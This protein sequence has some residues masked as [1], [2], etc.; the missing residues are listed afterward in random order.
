[1]KFYYVRLILTN[2]LSLFSNKIIL[3][4]TKI[5]K[6]RTISKLLS[7]R[8][9]LFVKEV[10]KHGTIL[11]YNFIN[12]INIIELNYTQN[13]NINFCRIKNFA[14]LNVVLLA[15]WDPQGIVDSYVLYYAK[16]LKEIGYSIIL[17]SAN[18]VF[19]DDRITDIFDAVIYRKTPGYDFSSW[20]AAFDSLPTLFDVKQLILTNDSV[21]GPIGSLD[22]IFN[23]MKPIIC[24]FWGIIESLT[25][26]PY[27]QSYFI[28]L[29][30]NVIKSKAFRM[31][32]NSIGSSGDR[33]VAVSYEEI[34]SQWL[35]CNNLIGAARFPASI[36]NKNAVDPVYHASELIQTKQF[37]FLKRRMIFNN[38]YAIIL[39]NLSSLLKENEY[40]I[41]LIT[42]YS[43]RLHL[44]LSVK[45][46]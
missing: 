43:K 16:H 32:L 13:A 45:L 1:M 39:N 4:F 40:P 34:L 14:G 15:H 33:E 29:F 44:N 7:T 2:I 36:F 18:N 17:C 21:F 28:L 38:P 41:Q 31:F 6:F 25:L 12:P 10:P 3:Y 19:I 5:P 8:N 22:N 20:K 11:K 23:A 30:H 24:D 37:P 42:D 9:N 27:L 35:I 26:R 46:E